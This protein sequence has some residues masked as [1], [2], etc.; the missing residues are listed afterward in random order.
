M[1]KSIRDLI[2]AELG[3]DTIRVSDN[4]L[5]VDVDTADKIILKADPMRYAFVLVN[6][7]ANNVYIKPRRAVVGTAGILVA[8][9]GGFIAFNWR[10]DLILPAVEWHALAASDN[11][12][13]EIYAV[14]GE[15]D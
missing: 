10:D 13:I 1:S 11:S 14:E 7:S 2:A 8:A 9:S 12:S 5:G 6:V 15:P 3:I 4:P